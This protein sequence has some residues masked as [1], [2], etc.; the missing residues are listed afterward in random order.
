MAVGNKLFLFHQQSG[1]LGFFTAPSHTPLLAWMSS[2]PQGLWLGSSL[3]TLFLLAV[4][5]S[6]QV[7]CWR[8]GVREHPALPDSK[9]QKAARYSGWGGT[10]FSPHAPQP[11][12][13]L[14]DVLRLSNLGAERVWQ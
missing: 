11:L 10:L 4:L 12:C 1:H 7:H 13:T 14:E 9:S 6:A 3:G 5:L 8:G 2:V